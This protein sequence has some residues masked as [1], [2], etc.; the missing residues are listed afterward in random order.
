MSARQRPPA[1]PFGRCRRSRMSVPD[2]S[3]CPSLGGGRESGR[4]DPL[5]GRRSGPILAGLARTESGKMLRCAFGLAGGLE[6]AGSAVSHPPLNPFLPES[7]DVR[8]MRGGTDTPTRRASGRGARVRA[9]AYGRA[10]DRSVS[11][12]VL[13][14][15]ESRALVRGVGPTQS[16][17]EPVS[18]FVRINP[19]CAR[20]ARFRPD[21]RSGSDGRRGRRRWGG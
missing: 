13:P 18:T 6:E 20:R 5:P 17:G 12:H 14:S 9:L 7:G 19:A 21:R 11:P 4:C 15:R 8:F 2:P 10:V 16:G 3:G 1:P